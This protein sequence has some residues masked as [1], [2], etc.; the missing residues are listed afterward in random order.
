MDEQQA[1]QLR[2]EKL[3]VHER[4]MEVLK[5]IEWDHDGNAISHELTEDELAAVY[6][7]NLNGLGTPGSS[8]QLEAWLQGETIE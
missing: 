7:R 8:P 4:T 5:D 1:E 2:Q 6:E 3:E